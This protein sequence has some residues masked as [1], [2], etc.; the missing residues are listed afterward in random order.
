MMMI[1]MTF[2]IQFSLLPPPSSVQHLFEHYPT[3]HQ[4]TTTTTIIIGS[5]IL[6]MLH[7]KSQK[8]SPHD[9][10][11]AFIASNSIN[12]IEHNK[13]MAIPTHETG[14]ILGILTLL[15]EH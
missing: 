12:F 5:R 9:C 1:I 15:G 6:K 10:A 14:N 2:N 8:S 4:T 3:I 7:E 11:P 13:M